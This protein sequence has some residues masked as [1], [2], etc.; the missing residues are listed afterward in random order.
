MPALGADLEDFL[1]KVLDARVLDKAR[2]ICITEEIFNVATLEDLRDGN[3]LKEIFARGTAARIRKALPGQ[4]C[5]MLVTGVAGD[6]RFNESILL[7]FA[8]QLR[9]K[10]RIPVI[11]LLLLFLLLL[12]LAIPV[13]WP[14][15]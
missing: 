12:L 15:N 11:T 2:Q 5:L 3:E 7:C 1:A 9:P 10:M 8:P 4:L 6:V 14:H 13:I